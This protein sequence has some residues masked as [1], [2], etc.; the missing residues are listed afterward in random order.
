LHWQSVRPVPRVT[1]DFGDGRK[2][3]RTITGNS[4]HYAL[5]ADGTPLD[6]LPG[7]YGPQQ[8]LAWLAEV[9]S[10]GGKLDRLSGED[11]AAP[12]R[13]YH[14]ARVAEIAR[15]WA[16]DLE[17]VAPEAAAG[18]S[19]GASELAKVT[20]DE[21][22]EKIALLPSHA[23]ELDATS[24]NII[25]RDNPDAVRAGNIAV[26]KRAAEFPIVRLVVNLQR[27]VA[28][29]GVRN[30]Y[31]LHARAHE[32]FAAGSVPPDIGQL[33]ARVYA[34]LFLTPAGDPWLGLAPADTYTALER[35]GVVST[36]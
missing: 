27:S 18:R 2:L 34:E 12:L 20:T 11:R 15:Q 30:E 3:E 10:L 23:V 26:T 1:I 6:V 9:E 36:R 21:I 14:A 5:A 4:A 22:W 28:E 16:A 13:E 32:W 17:A 33:N 25:L 24:R 19:T 35:G 29:D 31:T 8:F 7:L